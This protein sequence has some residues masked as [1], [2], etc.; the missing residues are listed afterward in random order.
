MSAT[1]DRS[2]IPYWRP[3][4]PEGYAP[5]PL[6]GVVCLRCRCVVDNTPTGIAGHEQYHEGL[7]QLWAMFSKAAVDRAAQVQQVAE[8]SA[9]DPP[10]GAAPAV[11]PAASSER[12]GASPAPARGRAPAPTAAPGPQQDGGGA[13]PGGSPDRDE[14]DPWYKGQPPPEP[15]EG[16]P[17]PEGWEAADD[18]VSQP[19]HSPPATP[20][21]SPPETSG[22]G[23]L[24]AGYVTEWCARRR[25]NTST[26][27]AFLRRDIAADFGPR[28]RWPVADRVDLAELSGEG[29]TV[30]IAKLQAKFPGLQAIDERAVG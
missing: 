2:R 11:P 30:A 8:R 1:T 23:W 29:A 3:G 10:P 14:D 27:A 25:L 9:A 22:E 20:P 17:E 21:A 4:A 24:P 19:D 5:P 28:G 12:R 26:A 7:R 18:Q 15:G 13:G 16:E 6:V